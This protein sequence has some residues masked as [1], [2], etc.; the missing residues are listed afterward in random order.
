MNVKM[1]STSVRMLHLVAADGAAKLDRLSLD[2]GAA[3]HMKGNLLG[4]FDRVAER[5]VGITCSLSYSF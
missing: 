3:Y 1:V 4:K 2:D 5:V